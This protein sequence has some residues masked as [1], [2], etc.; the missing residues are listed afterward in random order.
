MKI[1]WLGHSCFHITTKKGTV[2]ITDPY[3][4]TIGYGRIKEKADA[5]S[6]SHKHQDHSDISS[7]EGIKAVFD[8]PGSFSYEDITAKGISSYHDKEKGAKRGGNIIYNFRIDG[9]NICHLGDL[10]HKLDPAAKESIGNVDILLIPVGGYYTIDHEEAYQTVLLLDPKLTIPMHYKT[11]AISFP[12]SSPEAF[13][14]YFNTKKIYRTNML[15]TD[16]SGISDLSGIVMLNY[17]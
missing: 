10:G 3:N 5:V 13:L 15:D 11:E 1:K 14:S 2:L 16:F 6:I 9:S 8:K 7:I 4:S 12:I 17:K